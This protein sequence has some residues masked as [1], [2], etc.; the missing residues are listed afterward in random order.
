MR[1]RHVAYERAR[2]SPSTL[3]HCAATVSLTAGRPS[4]RWGAWLAV[5]S[6]PPRL[7]GGGRGRRDE[8]A[9][10][11]RVVGS[12]SAVPRLDG[13]AS[14]Q[15]A[16]RTTVRRVC[17]AV[18]APARVRARRRGR[19]RA[20]SRQWPSAGSR[21]STRR[22]PCVGGWMRRCVYRTLLSIGRPR[23]ASDGGDP[24]RLGH[25]RRAGRCALLRRA[26]CDRP[27]A[28]PRAPS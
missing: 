13:A 15:S 14:E 3:R 8:K 26:S 10:S 24:E 25:R 23:L 22:R 20:R 2:D 1:L 21:S 7:V 17:A 4:R 11:R 12:V 6:L 19:A 28:A 16:R 18:G 9:R 27:P 5:R